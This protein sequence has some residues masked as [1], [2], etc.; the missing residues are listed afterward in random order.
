MQYHKTMKLTQGS[1][2][3][4]HLQNWFCKMLGNIADIYAHNNI[5]NKQTKTLDTQHTSCGIC[6]TRASV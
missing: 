1:E 6:C 4:R 2:L 5:T 3:G